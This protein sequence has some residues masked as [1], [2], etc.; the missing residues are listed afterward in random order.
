MRHQI[1]G[2]FTAVQGYL[3]QVGI[4]AKLEPWLLLC[5][6]KQQVAGKNALLYM[7]I[8]SGAHIDLVIS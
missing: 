7:N 5:C 4:E 1:K 6:S 8:S 3:A 2:F